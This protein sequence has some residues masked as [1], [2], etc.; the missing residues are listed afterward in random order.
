ML[1][2]LRSKAFVR[3]G[4]RRSSNHHR[5]NEAGDR[6]ARIDEIAGVADLLEVSLDTLLGRSTTPK[7]DKMYAFRALL[8][9]TRRAEAE[10]S[11]AEAT[12]REI[13]DMTICRCGPAACRS[14]ARSGLRA[15]GLAP[16][17]LDRH[18]SS[19]GRY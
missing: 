12:L 9:A 19:S 14:A 1:T 15:W 17:R 8:D 4:N 3:Q 11:T 7:N 10:V 18:T 6:A 16:P 13:P 5:Q 2:G